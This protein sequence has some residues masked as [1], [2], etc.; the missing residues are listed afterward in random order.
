M[1]NLW[2]CAKKNVAES[3]KKKEVWK[4]PDPALPR[5]SQDTA[6]DVAGVEL[7][8]DDTFRP[9]V[10]RSFVSAAGETRTDHIKSATP[11]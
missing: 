3:S 6:H 7:D 2:C 1:G 8:L 5:P 11:D 9:S 4:D 10:D